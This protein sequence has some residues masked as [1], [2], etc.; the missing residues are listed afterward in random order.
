MS[1]ETNMIVLRRFIEEAW[2][3]GN[4]R[5]IDE[6]FSQDYVYHPA[7][8]VDRELRGTEGIKQ[9]VNFYRSAFPDLRVTVEEMFGDRDEAVVRMSWYGTHRGQFLNA[10]PTGR[11]VVFS[12]IN[13]NRFA[14]GK[15]AETWPAVDIMWALQQLGVAGAAGPTG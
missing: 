10:A 7:Y 15:I 3:N 4:I 6:L 5:V 9:L 8:F 2:N 12:W 1:V 11:Q 13:I 14:N